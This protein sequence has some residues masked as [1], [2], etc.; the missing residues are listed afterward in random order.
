MI[1]PRLKRVVEQ[2]YERSIE[3]QEVYADLLE[4]MLEQ[5]A[6]SAPSSEELKTI[7]AESMRKHAGTLE[8]L[9]DK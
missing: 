1:S 7:V 8:Y 5:A 4:R 6:Q 2:A 3:Q 9:R